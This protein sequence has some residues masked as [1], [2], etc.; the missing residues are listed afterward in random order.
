MAKF[1]VG[2]IIKAN[3]ESNERY[4]RVELRFFNC[5]GLYL[6]RYYSTDMLEK[7]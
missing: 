6:G 5:D 1:K 2:D 3:K 7:V 4:S